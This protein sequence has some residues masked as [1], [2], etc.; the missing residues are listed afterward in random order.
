MIIKEIVDYCCSEKVVNKDSYELR[1][2]KVVYKHHQ[3]FRLTS[4]KN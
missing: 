2:Q 4:I 3:N 1:F